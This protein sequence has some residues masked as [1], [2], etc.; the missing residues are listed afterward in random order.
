MKLLPVLIAAFTVLALSSCE[1]GGESE[2]L[3]TGITMRDETCA[4]GSLV[5][6]SDWLPKGCTVGKTLHDRVLDETEDGCMLNSLTACPNPCNSGTTIQF[7]VNKPGFMKI[8][9]LDKPDSE[10][11]T[12]LEKQVDEGTNALSVNCYTLNLKAAVYRVQFSFR[13]NGSDEVYESFGDI[14]VE[15]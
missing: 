11:A 6:S 2:D 1:H 5:D 14:K 7:T 9:L 8:I 15:Y 12:L 4:P 10:L 3:F 13:P